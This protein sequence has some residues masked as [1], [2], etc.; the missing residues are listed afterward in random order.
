MKINKQPFRGHAN[1]LHASVVLRLHYLTK[2]MLNNALHLL[3]NE[4]HAAETGL[5]QSA[6]LSL[7]EQFK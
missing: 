1:H 3:V 6:D 7:D 2:C 4:F 5:F